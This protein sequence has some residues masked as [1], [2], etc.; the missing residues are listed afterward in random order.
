MSGLYHLIENVD[1]PIHGLGRVVLEGPCPD[2]ETCQLDHVLYTGAV[3]FK[4]VVYAELRRGWGWTWQAR[5]M[6]R[7]SFGDAFPRT[8]WN[9][10]FL[11]RAKAEAWATKAI[12]EISKPEAPPIVFMPEEIVSDAPHP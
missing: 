2:E 1:P 5:V 6:R 7:G 8:P 4:P 9:T 11:T 12:A 3:P 10:G